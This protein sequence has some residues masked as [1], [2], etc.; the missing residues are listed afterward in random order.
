MVDQQILKLFEEV[1]SKTRA[2]KIA[3]H[4]TAE[5]STFMAAIGGQFTLSVS[6]WTEP[7]SPTAEADVP[8]HRYAL[9]LEDQTGSELARITESDEGI[10]AADLRELYE[11]ARRRAVRA[12]EKIGDVLEVLSRL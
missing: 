8:V 1:L 12:D 6:A 11:A 3:W 5:E 7:A 2:G 10:H 4:P 9:V